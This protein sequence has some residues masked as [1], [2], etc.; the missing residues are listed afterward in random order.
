MGLEKKHS[1][2]FTVYTN[3]AGYTYLSLDFSTRLAMFEFGKTLMSE[4]LFEYWH[5]SFE[6]NA[7]DFGDGPEC[8][9]GVRYSDKKKNIH[10]SYG[11]DDELLDE[12][13]GIVSEDEFR[14]TKKE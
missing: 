14:N 4:A 12:D 8:I 6:L 2:D 3:P 5:G 1:L 9:N 7:Y 11:T 13:I 10:V